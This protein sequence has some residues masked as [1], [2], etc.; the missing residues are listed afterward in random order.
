ML[1]KC[2]TR[3][4]PFQGWGP[5]TKSPGSN[6]LR[7]SLRPGMT[8]TRSLR[9]PNNATAPPAARTPSA[10]SPPPPLKKQPGTLSSY[11]PVT[12]L[13]SAPTAG[14]RTSGLKRPSTR[15]RRPRSGGAPVTAMISAT[16]GTAEDRL[17]AGQL[18]ALWSDP[19]QPHGRSGV[20]KLVNLAALLSA[21]GLALVVWRKR[22]LQLKQVEYPTSY[23]CTIT[24]PPYDNYGV[25]RVFH[26]SLRS[27]QDPQPIHSCSSLRISHD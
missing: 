5:M 7:C 14:G 3:S 23:L 19:D 4:R 18:G 15:R 24:V 20:L 16:T 26:C 6:P 1:T 22:K 12:E 2:K 27:R 17:Q 13:S 9:C 10:S 11:E 25:L 21:V 8:P